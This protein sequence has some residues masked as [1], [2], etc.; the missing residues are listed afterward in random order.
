MLSTLQNE[1]RAFGH[2]RQV[3]LIAEK[4]SF[5][6]VFLRFK[7]LIWS[8][9]SSLLVIAR[10]VSFSLLKTALAQKA[11]VFFCGAPLV[12][13]LAVVMVRVLR[14]A[15]EVKSGLVQKFQ[16][17]LHKVLFYIEAIM[18]HLWWEKQLCVARFGAGLEQLLGL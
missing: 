11:G 18:R 17:R 4:S 9:T 13:A 7:L 1:R 5:V 12:V 3:F 8:D 10:T 15:G 2:V 14:P 16:Q 6:T